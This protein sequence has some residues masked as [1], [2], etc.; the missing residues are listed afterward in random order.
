MLLFEISTK[1]FLP[2]IF[3]LL[4]SV[5]VQII[6]RATKIKFIPAF[7]IELVIGILIAKPFNNFIEQNNFGD[8]VDG[9][10]V[11]GLSLIMFLSGYDVD[12]FRI[13]K[14]AQKFHNLKWSIII[15]VLIYVVGF[16]LSWIFVEGENKLSQ[17]LLITLVMTSVFAGLVVPLVQSTGVISSSVGQF[18]ST[19][20]SISE[21]LSILLLSIYMV[22][23]DMSSGNW[24]FGVIMFAIILFV[25]D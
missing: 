21:L 15:L 16:G 5:I 17:S 7:V 22:V 4:I 25:L 24:Y 18:I 9:I 1:F 11:L 8:L 2:I 19:F 6:L 12:A 3:L 13:K 10:Y 23:I 20:A 14:K